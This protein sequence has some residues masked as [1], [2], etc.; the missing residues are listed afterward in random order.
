MGGVHA[1]R[2]WAVFL[3]RAG[4]LLAGLVALRSSIT[5]VT[6]IGNGIHMLATGYGDG[7][8]SNFVQGGWLESTVQMIVWSLLC[9]GLARYSLPL[10]VWL[11]PADNV[12]GGGSCARCGHPMVKANKGVCPECG[13][14]G[15]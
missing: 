8:L 5:F 11:T 2:R 15:Q 6:M 1:L 4:A 14:A 10:A 7:I 9:I 12:L 3:L 13:L